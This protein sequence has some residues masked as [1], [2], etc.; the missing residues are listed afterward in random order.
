MF[1][2]LLL[3]LLFVFGLYS[4]GFADY[5]TYYDGVDS[6][7]TGSSISWAD[8][9][10][11]IT[12]GFLAAEMA[13][14]RNR[15]PLLAFILGILCGVFALIGYWIAGDKKEKVIVVDK[16]EGEVKKGVVVVDK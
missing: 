13:R 11:W 12:S 10:F 15:S 9:Y 16:A 2:K 3:V 1:K 5:Y 7:A 14:S 4:V 6:Y 8:V